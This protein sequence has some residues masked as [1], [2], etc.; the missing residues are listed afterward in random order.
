MAPA[1]LIA[2]TFGMELSSGTLR[3]RTDAQGPKRNRIFG[4]SL[5]KVALP[6]QLRRSTDGAASP[7]RMGLL[8]GR[9]EAWNA[10][11]PVVATAEARLAILEFAVT[12]SAR[13]EI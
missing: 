8:P 4:K 10:V 7:V 5:T 3:L 6:L 9:R 2:A 11:V 12:V 13:F 1:S